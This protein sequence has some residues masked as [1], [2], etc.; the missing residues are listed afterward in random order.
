[1]NI[2][3]SALPGKTLERIALTSTPTGRG[4]PIGMAVAKELTIP[5]RHGLAEV[6]AMSRRE[7][8]LLYLRDMLEHL[9]SCQRQLEWS[10]NPET[11]RVIAETMIRELDF[12]RTVCEDIRQKVS[13]RPALSD[14]LFPR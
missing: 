14:S 2:S 8:N 6:E 5:T 12:C 1:L 13:P 11:V 7:V 4:R 3:F 10:K 9:K